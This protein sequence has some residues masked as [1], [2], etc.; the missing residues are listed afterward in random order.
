MAN[1]TCP[2]PSL[3]P[4][5]SLAWTPRTTPKSF[6]GNNLAQIV[7]LRAGQEASLPVPGCRLDTLVSTASLSFPPFHWL[8]A[9]GRLPACAQT[10]H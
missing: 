8:G 6:G 10:L 7:N 5:P 9:Q 1:V 3:P 2:H 4:K